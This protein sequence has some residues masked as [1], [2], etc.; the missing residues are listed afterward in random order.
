MMKES[1]LWRRRKENFSSRYKNW[2]KDIKRICKN[3][4][5]NCKCTRANVMRMKKLAKHK[6]KGSKNST[7]S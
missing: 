5:S 2:K 1:K 7:L 6:S 4:K 3:T